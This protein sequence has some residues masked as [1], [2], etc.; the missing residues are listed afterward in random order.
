MINA[1]FIY[2]VT[3]RIMAGFVMI[4]KS[5]ICHWVRYKKDPMIFNYL[6]IK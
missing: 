4:S 5:A 2:S 1:Y 6:E 3:P